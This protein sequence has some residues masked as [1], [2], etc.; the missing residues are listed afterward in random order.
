M[1]ASLTPSKAAPILTR[2]SGGPILRGSDFPESGRIARVFNSGII[3]HDGR[4]IMACRTEDRGLR[5]TIWIAESRDGY[6]FAPRPAPI[7]VPSHNPLWREYTEGMYY[8]P[9]ITKLDGVFYLVHA[10]H[11]KHGCRLSLLRT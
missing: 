3:K 4:Y 7:A 1:D 8:D 9:R 5:D 10:A 6:H 2:H 11:S